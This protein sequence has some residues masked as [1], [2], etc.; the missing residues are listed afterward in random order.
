M[1]HILLKRIV[2]II[3]AQLTHLNRNANEKSKICFR[4]MEKK[5]PKDMICTV[6][7]CKAVITFIQINKEK[8][9]IKEIENYTIA[10]RG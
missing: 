6:F 4:K 7:L 10:E 9:P 3:T 5:T 1:K 8:V 2:K